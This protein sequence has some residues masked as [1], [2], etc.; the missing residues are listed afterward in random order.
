MSHRVVSR[1]EWI[2]ARKALLSK[3]KEFTQQREQLSQARRDLPWERV[4]EDYVFD[5]P[6]GKETLAQLFDN[7]PQLVVY[8]FMFDP[9]WVSG[10]K[11]CSFWADNLEPNVVHLKHRDVTPVVISRAPLAKLQAFQR[12][13][14][15]RFK[16]LSSHG[17]SFNYDFHVSFTPEQ[18]ADGSALYNFT[19]HDPGF[20]EREGLSTFRRGSDGAVYHTYSCYARG[21]DMI[22]GTYQLL[23]LT[24]KGRDEDDLAGPQAWVRYHD[25]YDR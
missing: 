21:I 25:R 1:A 10:C 16:W 13:M 19:D 11:S 18:L 5:T 4:E 14:G 15:W 12:R 7:R 24:S 22:N 6:D 3:E 17:N 9:E 20:G 2:E 23:D 8:H